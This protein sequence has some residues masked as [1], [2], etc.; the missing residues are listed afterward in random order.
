MFCVLKC[1]SVSFLD[2]TVLLDYW[3]F[4]ERRM[5]AMQSA[6]DF[7]NP[8]VVDKEL[9]EFIVVIKVAVIESTKLEINKFIF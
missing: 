5:I 6:F 3:Y 8:Q 2:G 7:F 9:M 1:H 4:V